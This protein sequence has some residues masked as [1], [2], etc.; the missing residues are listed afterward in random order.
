MTT[1]RYHVHEKTVAE[2]L[3]HLIRSHGLRSAHYFG[4][5]D[6]NVILALKAEP[7]FE[8]GVTDY[9]DRWN[10][11]KFFWSDEYDNLV[12]P[13][14]EVPEWLDGV[15]TYEEGY[16]DTNFLIYDLPLGI[17]GRQDD[18]AL[19]EFLDPNPSGRKTRIDFVA[20]L[21]PEPS[22]LKEAHSRFVWLPCYSGWLG[23]RKVGAGNERG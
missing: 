16:H 12:G 22:R 2:N 5:A 15:T 10:R 1:R 13:D 9:W 11:S 3:L 20:L 7:G 8:F 14:D 21:R 4:F 18:L 6:K 23:S 19:G 17:E